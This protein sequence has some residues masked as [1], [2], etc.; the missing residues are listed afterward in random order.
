MQHFDDKRASI[1]SC[2]CSMMLRMGL[3]NKKTGKNNNKYGH[4]RAIFPQMAV[5]TGNFPALEKLTKRWRKY[6]Q[7]KQMTHA[8]QV[9]KFP[10]K[11]INFS[12]LFLELD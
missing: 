7:T 6:D 11:E 2:S 9:P 10:Q 4:R 3:I 12:K 1:N 8:Y 5:K